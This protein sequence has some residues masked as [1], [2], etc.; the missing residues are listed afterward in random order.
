MGCDPGRLTCLAS[1]WPVEVE[2]AVD[3][4]HGTLVAVGLS[5]GLLRRL[6][7]I[8]VIPDA[9]VAKLPMSKYDK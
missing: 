1:K 3:A 8:V 4:R 2:T 9:K 7:L 6:E 5:Q